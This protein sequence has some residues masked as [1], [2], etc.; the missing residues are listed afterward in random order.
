MIHAVRCSTWVRL[1][2]QCVLVTYPL[3]MFQILPLHRNV[4]LSHTSHD[5]ITVHGVSS[6]VSHKSS[7]LKT[8]NIMGRRRHGGGGCVVVT[9]LK[10]QVML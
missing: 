1:V 4:A 6:R 5:G 10:V 3:Y 9:V 8:L 7:I 2:R